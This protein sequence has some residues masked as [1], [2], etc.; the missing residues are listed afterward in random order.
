MKSLFAILIT[1]LLSTAA[2]GQSEEFTSNLLQSWE[3][4]EMKN[5][6]GLDLPLSEDAKMRLHFDTNNTVTA[7]YKTE[8]A[9]GAW[10]YDPNKE[11]LFILDKSTKVTVTYKLLELTK[12]RLVL[13]YPNEVD[14]IRT[15]IFAPME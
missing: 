12:D 8:K 9:P 6:E 2:F 7:E 10:K 13:Y 14:G 11:E 3:L 15:L 5:M 4:A 1:V